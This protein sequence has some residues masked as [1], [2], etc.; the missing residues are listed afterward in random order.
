MGLKLGIE[1]LRSFDG[2][3]RDLR[4]NYGGSDRKDGLLGPD[5]S[6]YMVKY[7]EKQAPRN[8]LATNY[9]NNVVS[10]YVSSHV[11]GILGYPVHDTELGTLDGEV[12]VVCR[13]FVP[14]CGELLEFGIFLR[15]HYDSG[16]IGRIPDIEQIYEVFEMD[17]M[18]SPQEGL[19]KIPNKSISD[20]TLPIS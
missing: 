15:K 20:K 10:E 11:L 18:L 3:P 2:W 17:P 9:V 16:A 6:R 1:G 13:N 8:D 4:A 19:F 7:S 12:V 5:N 14:P